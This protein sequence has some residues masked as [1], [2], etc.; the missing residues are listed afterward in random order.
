MK[1]WFSLAL[2]IAMCLSLAACGK[3]GAG[4]TGGTQDQSGAGSSGGTSAA[5]DGSDLA[6]VQDKGTLVVGITEFDPMDY[7][8]ADGNWIGFDAD[9]AKAF[10]ESLGVTA[11]FQLIEWDNK[12]M[13]LDGKTIDVVW[14]GMT[15]TDEVTSAMSCTN[16]Y[17]NNAQIVILPADVAEDYPDVESMS[18]LNFA[19]ESGSAGQ[20]Q[21]EENGFTFTEVVDQATAVMEV[22]SGTADAAIID[23]LMAGAMVGE[24][25]S[26]DQLTY[27]ISL[28]SEE[29]GVGFRQGSDLTEL[30]NQFFADS[31]AD[32]T[33]LEIAET[34]GVQA[35]IIPQE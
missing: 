6:F 16:A 1:K 29:Y 14:N 24:G 15:L 30:L 20:A 25:T 7:R 34:Y 9:M 32:G 12:V 19:V 27:T 33:M 21:A 8:D 17:C 13:E 28:N 31:Y 2:A 18:G 26:Y 22:A 10:A 11:E 4:S 23:S 3:D 35:A 5:G